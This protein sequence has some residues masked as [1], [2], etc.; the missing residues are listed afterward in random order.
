MVDVPRTRGKIAN[1]ATE[2]VGVGA[3][4]EE[5]IKITPE[6]IAAGVEVLSDNTEWTSNLSR[7]IADYVKDILR[8]ALAVALA[9]K[10][11]GGPK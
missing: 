9:E 2:S 11:K 8:A 4:E 6:M 5:L 1:A 7:G 3:P 10:L